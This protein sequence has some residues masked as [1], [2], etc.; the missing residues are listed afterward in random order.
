EAAPLRPRTECESNVEAILAGSSSPT[1]P[2]D[3]RNSDDDGAALLAPA[4]D[5][6]PADTASGSAPRA[7]VAPPPACTTESEIMIGTRRFV[8]DQRVASMLG[9]S[10]RTLSRWHAAAKGPP[11][12]KIGSKLIYDLDKLQ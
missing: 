6:L 12:K 4:E 5:Q 1:S 11:R 7:I 2:G 10:R 3:V 8:S 9:C